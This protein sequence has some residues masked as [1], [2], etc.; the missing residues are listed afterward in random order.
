MEKLEFVQRR[1]RGKIKRREPTL[2]VVNLEDNSGE[3]KRAVFKYHIS[4]IRRSTF[5]FNYKM[6]ESSMYLIIP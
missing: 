2:W 6:S 4:L 3:N 1:I 5:F